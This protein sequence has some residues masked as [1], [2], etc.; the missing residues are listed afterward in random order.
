MT[1]STGRCMLT[2]GLIGMLFLSA[3]AESAPPRPI[4]QVE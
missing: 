3:C 1:G 2:A 4:I